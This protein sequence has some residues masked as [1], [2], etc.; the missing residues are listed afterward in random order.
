MR[1]FNATPPLRA[2][3]QVAVKLAVAG[4]QIVKNPGPQD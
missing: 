2:N 3:A 4:L 1:H